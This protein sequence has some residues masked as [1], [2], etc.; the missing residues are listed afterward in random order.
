MGYTDGVGVQCREKTVNPRL[1]WNFKSITELSTGELWTFSRIG[2]YKRTFLSGHYGHGS[3]AAKAREGCNNTETALQR[4]GG[5]GE[6]TDT[7]GKKKECNKFHLQ[8][9][10]NRASVSRGTRHR[11]ERNATQRRSGEDVEWDRWEK[12]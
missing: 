10:K 6:P 12:V 8:S 2:V 11:I 1:L 7:V 3:V 9:G 4:R 5:G